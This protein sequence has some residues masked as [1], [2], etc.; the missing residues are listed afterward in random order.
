[1][2]KM[3]LFLAVVFV[4][5]IGYAAATYTITQSDQTKLDVFL[6]SKI[7]PMIEKRLKTT[8]DPIKQAQ[9]LKATLPLIKFVWNGWKERNATLTKMA[10]E[11]IQSKYSQLLQKWAITKTTSIKNKNSWKLST[12]E[13]SGTYPD[14]TARVAF[15]SGKRAMFFSPTTLNRSYDRNWS[16][17]N[18]NW[19]VMTNILNYCKKVYPNWSPR[20]NVTSVEEYQNENI[21]NRKPFCQTYG[22]PQSFSWF[23]AC[24]NSAWNSES[25]NVMTYKCNWPEFYFDLKPHQLSYYKPIWVNGYNKAIIQIYVENIWNIKS[26]YSKASLYI[27]NVLEKE[28]TK[29]PIEW[30]LWN[31]WLS[32]T[33]NWVGTHEAKVEITTLWWE[34]KNT[35]NN[36]SSVTFTT[37]WWTTPP[38][39][40]PT[41]PAQTLDFDLNVKQLNVT[42]IWNTNKY[43]IVANIEN[44]WNGRSSDFK[45]RLKINGNLEK[46]ETMLKLYKWSN[47]LFPTLLNT[48]YTL[49]EWINHEIIVEVQA[50]SWTDSNITNNTKTVNIWE[51]TTNSTDGLSIQSINFQKY[52][53]TNVWIFPTVINNNRS[54][55]ILPNKIDTVK[56]ISFQLW[57]NIKNNW[58]TT[59]AL[60]YNNNTI[61]NRVY[62]WN[63]TYTTYNSTL[64]WYITTVNCKI[65]DNNW[66]LLWDNITFNVLQQVNSTTSAWKIKANQIVSFYTIAGFPVQE[67]IWNI[68]YEA[69]IWQRELDCTIWWQNNNNVTKN[70]EIKNQTTTS[71]QTIKEI[72]FALWAWFINKYYNNTSK[73]RE[74]DPEQRVGY[75][76]ISWCYLLQGQENINCQAAA[77]KNICKYYYPESIWGIIKSKV[78]YLEKLGLWKKTGQGWS[79]SAGLAFM[80]YRCI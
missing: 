18:E 10:Q 53:S 68:L 71:T 36:T 20:W 62:T 21:S 15:L 12:T 16:S 70:I 77:I 17:K 1:M 66:N 13:V 7:I 6:N 69:G 34:D 43:N 56:W 54:I 40:P 59:V 75:N 33:Y 5:I 60:A 47:V 76:N 49:Q 19:N 28:W 23:T 63:G 29:L 57:F 25:I 45:A 32:Y 3:Y 39:I 4:W 72:A 55:Q 67:T 50:L 46:E 51:T 52:T 78:W 9:I 80:V 8:Q 38:I 2:K 65:K 79:F 14:T 30:N 74:N 27:D 11:Q 73:A 44:N 42:R 24:L 26:P 48:Q 22:N 41:P 35:N 64:G 37:N 31:Y 58:N 61:E